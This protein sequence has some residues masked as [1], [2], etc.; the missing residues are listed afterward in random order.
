MIALLDANMLIA[1]FDA[2]HIHHRDAHTWLAKNRSRGWA[3]CPLTQNA[4]VR[5]ISQANYPGRLPIADITRRLSQATSAVDHHFWLDDVSIC[6]TALFDYSVM[7]TSRHLTDHY[8]LALAMTRKGC[9]VTFDK[10]ILLPP[11][12]GATSRN[13]LVL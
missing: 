2:A 3:T 5:I 11:V 12:R 8:L 7:L 10:G 13:L 6:D 9:L 1:L 4:C